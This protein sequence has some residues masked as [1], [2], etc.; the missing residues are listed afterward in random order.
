M[1]TQ[2]NASQ[3]AIAHPV[4]PATPRTLYPILD[5][6]KFVL[7]FFVIAEHTTVLSSLTGVWLH[8]G[9]SLLWPAVDIFYVISGFL[10]F[11]KAQAAPPR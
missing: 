4:H 5:S 11:D 9:Q 2:H 6:L 7:A 1:G 8:I 10:C 3:Q